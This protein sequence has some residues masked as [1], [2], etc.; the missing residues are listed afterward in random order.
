MLYNSMH[1]VDEHRLLYP[2][3]KI[4]LDC[5]P[6]NCNKESQGKL[7]R[8]LNTTY[9]FLFSSRLRAANYSHCTLAQ[10]ENLVCLRTASLCSGTGVK[11]RRIPLDL[12]FAQL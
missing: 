3:G 10:Q 11:P 7:A 8:R 1:F 2:V 5:R 9:H 4:P 12:R 6:L